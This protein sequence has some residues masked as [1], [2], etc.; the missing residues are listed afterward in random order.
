[1][2]EQKFISEIVNSLE[3]AGCAF[4]YKPADSP[5][6]WTQSATRFTPSKPCDIITCDLNGMILIECKQQRKPEAF[7]LNAMRP[8]QI[9]SLTEVVKMNQRA[10]VFLNRRFKAPHPYENSCYVFEWSE[11]V[12]RWKTHGSITQKDFKMCDFKIPVSKMLIVQ[13]KKERFDLSKLL[14]IEKNSYGF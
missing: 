7:G 12:K 10:Y 13:G 14:T 8:S 11:L 6:S 2:K 5:M 1:M 3:D 4:V 9:K